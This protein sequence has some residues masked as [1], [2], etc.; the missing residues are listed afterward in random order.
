ML[1]LMMLARR[2]RKAKR[3]LH[4]NGAQPQIHVLIEYVGLHRLDGVM[5][6]PQPAPA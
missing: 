3:R 2:L 5:V 1:D 4:L 6:E